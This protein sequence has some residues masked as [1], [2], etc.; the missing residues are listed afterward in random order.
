[1]QVQDSSDNVTRLT[2]SD[3]IVII[4][5]FQFRNPDMGLGQG[6]RVDNSVSSWMSM[7][8]ELVFISSTIKLFN[9]D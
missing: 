6:L 8:K 7:I 9:I 3:Q 5:S 1:M 4:Q 2:S